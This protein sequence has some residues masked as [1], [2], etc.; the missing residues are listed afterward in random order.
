M[1]QRHLPC[2]D[3]GGSDSLF[4]NELLSYCFRC[5]IC[6]DLPTGSKQH[7]FDN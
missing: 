2:P 3:C 7:I 5:F 4:K 1:E 6:T